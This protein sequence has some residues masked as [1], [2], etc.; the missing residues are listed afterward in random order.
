MERIRNRHFSKVF[1]GTNSELISMGRIYWDEYGPSRGTPSWRWRIEW[2]QLLTLSFLTFSC[3]LR[4]QE[5]NRCISLSRVLSSQSAA[6]QIS[7]ISARHMNL[8]PP[9]FSW[10]ISN[11]IRLLRRRQSEN[12]S[13]SFCMSSTRW[14]VGMK[15]L[16]RPLWSPQIAKCMYLRRKG[17][18]IE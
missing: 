4:E 18:F 12:I 6:F 2:Y 16:R 14:H 8:S 3:V 15:G 11:D 1:N 5:K 17:S 10:K 7:V 9:S 13:F